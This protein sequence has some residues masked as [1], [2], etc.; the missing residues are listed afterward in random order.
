MNEQGREKDDY[1]QR[2]VMTCEEMASHAMG[3][4]EQKADSTPK[5]LMYSFCVD[6]G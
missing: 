6:A 1:G 5:G 4:D 3:L 2:E